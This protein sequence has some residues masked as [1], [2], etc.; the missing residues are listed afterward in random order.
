MVRNEGSA[1]S[2][3]LTGGNY[4]MR[5]QSVET[6]LSVSDKVPKICI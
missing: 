5:G 3:I 2:L 6:C 1:S 4:K